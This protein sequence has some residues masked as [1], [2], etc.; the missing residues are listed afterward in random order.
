MPE[1]VNRED[2]KPKPGEEVLYEGVPHIVTQ[3]GLR[4]V[5]M[6][7]KSDEKH[8]ITVAQITKVHKPIPLPENIKLEGFTGP[9]KL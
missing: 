6:Y 9:P 2:L 4:W 8:T 1:V 3:V 5:H 7:K